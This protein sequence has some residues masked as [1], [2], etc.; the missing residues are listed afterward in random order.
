[1]DSFPITI[2][3]TVPVSLL[4]ILDL[5]LPVDNNLM[6]RM[7]KKV[8]PMYVVAMMLITYFN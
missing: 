2:Q 6:N 7:I 5:V 8:G 4:P 1:M 3:I